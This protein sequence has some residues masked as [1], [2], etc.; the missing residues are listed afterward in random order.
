MR[1][2]ARLTS[3]S[4]AP[5]FVQKSVTADSHGQEHLRANELGAF[6]SVEEFV[7]CRQRRSDERFALDFERVMM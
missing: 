3:P 6:E 1:G 4:R 7:S 5:R 2:P